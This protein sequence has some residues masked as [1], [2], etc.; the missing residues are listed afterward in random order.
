MFAVKLFLILILLNLTACSSGLN[1]IKLGEDS[2]SPWREAFV[3][4]MNGAENLAF[5]GKGS[6]YVSGL[7]GFIYKIRPTENPYRGY[8]ELKE[9][10]GD[11]CFDIE[12]GPDGFIYVGIEKKIGTRKVRR[13]AKLTENLL[14]LTYLSDHISD[15][16]GMA[17]DHQG[18]LYYT[19]SKLFSQKGVIYRVKFG[20]DENFKHPE[21]VID[22]V[23]LVNGLTFFHDGPDGPVLYYTELTNGVW[24]F[25]LNG[26]NE[27]PKQIFR[28]SG[29]LQIFDDLTTDRKGN[30]WF[31]VNSDRAMVLIKAPLENVQP[32]DAYRIGVLG[33][34]S[35]C[36]FG[37]GSGFRSDFLYITE[38]GL[39]G[40]SPVHN[41]RG[42]WVL[43]V[44][45][46][47]PKP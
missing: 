40:R 44:D 39:K 27:K 1:I 45:E 20:K 6:M 13:I 2:A 42:V 36:K 24:K 4:C 22:N 11:I 16:N 35:S 37:I 38:F 21:T 33:A 17:Q 34:P 23:G 18:Y 7:D 19:S 5:D 31:T 29:S 32:T 41:G 26:S 3:D 15:L 28:P 25:R 10:V 9:K 8:V 46:I 43:P 12:M 30:I 47:F 14:N